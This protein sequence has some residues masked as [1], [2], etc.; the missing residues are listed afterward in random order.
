[1]KQITESKKELLGVSVTLWLKQKIFI[2]GKC[3]HSRN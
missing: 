3:G 1:M 2:R